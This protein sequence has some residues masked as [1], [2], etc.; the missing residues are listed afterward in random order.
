M[1]EKLFAERGLSLDRLRVLIEV[2]DA[3]SIA[4]AAPGDPIRQSQ[5]S[6]QLRE[7]AEFFGCE[8]ATRRGKILKLTPQGV[9]LAELTRAHLRSL[10][11]F[12]AE[13]RA[14]TVDYTIAAGDSLIQW[15]VIPRIGALLESTPGVRFATANLRTNDIVQQLG[16]GRVDFGVIRKDALVAGLKSADLGTLTYCVVVPK[17]LAGRGKLA[18]REVLSRIPLAAQKADGQFTLR[19]REIAR[20]LGVELQPALACESFPHA[21]AAVRSGRFGAVV[22][23]IATSELEAGTY[24]EIASVELQNLRRD[25]VLAWNPRSIRV[26]PAAGRLAERL[27]NVLRLLPGS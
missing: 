19:F 2:H 24:V 22:P 4:Q 13:C 7:I 16:D 3:G 12:R 23:A 5:Y 11:D 26:R 18:L 9:R 27:K 10:E 21:L 1:F 20:A 14:E 6:R 8:V 25:L 17:R 15:L